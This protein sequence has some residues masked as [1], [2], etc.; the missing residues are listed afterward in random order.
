VTVAHQHKIDHLV[1]YSS[2]FS[3]QEMSPRLGGVSL[4]ANTTLLRKTKTPDHG[5]LIL[6]T[7]VVL[8]TMSKPTD[9]GLERSRVRVRVRAREWALICSS[10]E[11][12]FLLVEF[13]VRVQIA[14]AG[15]LW[16]TRAR[17]EAGLATFATCSA[18]TLERPDVTATDRTVTEQP[19]WTSSRSPRPTP[20]EPSGRPPSEAA[21]AAA[22]VGPTTT[23]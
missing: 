7:A 10:R 11:C 15:A 1:P 13:Y 21:A 8:D 23:S 2:K 6:G 20:V 9:F 22:M 16:V 19:T 12:T 5:D 3:D 18:A 14:S 17:G 4:P